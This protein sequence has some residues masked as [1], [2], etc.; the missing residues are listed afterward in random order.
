MPGDSRTDAA[1][2]DEYDVAHFPVPEIE[3]T[4]RL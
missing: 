3:S 2:Q 1:E 4:N